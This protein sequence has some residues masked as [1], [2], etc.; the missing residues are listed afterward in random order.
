MPARPARPPTYPWVRLNELDRNVYPTL[1]ADQAY[2]V[3]AEGDADHDFGIYIEAP[4]D[5]FLNPGRLFVFKM[6]FEEAPTQR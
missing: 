4:G 3:V 6:H 1:R 2:R 5:Q